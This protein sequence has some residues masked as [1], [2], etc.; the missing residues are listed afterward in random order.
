MQGVW[1]SPRHLLPGKVGSPL[2]PQRL[3]GA[4][5][6][7]G[8]QGLR[9]GGKGEAKKSGSACV[10]KLPGGGPGERGRKRCGEFGGRGVGVK[11]ALEFWGR[12]DMRGLEE[13]D[14]EHAGSLPPPQPCPPWLPQPLNAWSSSNPCPLVWLVPSVPWATVPHLPCLHESHTQSNSPASGARH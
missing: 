7:G 11:Q 12:G 9:T 4:S 8:W 13:E 1:V 6:L 5:D 2:P 10:C 3:V 14:E